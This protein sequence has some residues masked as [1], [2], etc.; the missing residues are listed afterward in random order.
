MITVHCL[1]AN[2]IFQFPSP[3]NVGLQHHFLSGIVIG[4][5]SAIIVNKP[6]DLF[7]HAKPIYSLIVQLELMVYK[8]NINVTLN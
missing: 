1:F 6:N 7:A 3:W 8:V 5:I 4:V 2:I